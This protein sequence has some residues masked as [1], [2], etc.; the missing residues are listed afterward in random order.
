VD[1]L[2]APQYTSNHS[3]REVK[4]QFMFQVSVSRPLPASI[5]F[6]SWKQGHG[7]HSPLDYNS[8]DMYALEDVKILVLEEKIKNENWEQKKHNTGCC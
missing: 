5:I 4:Y 3:G 2:S 7:I 8:T 1:T 6:C